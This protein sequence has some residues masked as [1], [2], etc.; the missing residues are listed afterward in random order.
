MLRVADDHTP[1]G[2]FVVFDEVGP[3]HLRLGLGR[4]SAPG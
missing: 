4:D 3:W 1:V 2:T